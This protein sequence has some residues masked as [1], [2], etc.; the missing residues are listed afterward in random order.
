MCQSLLVPRDGTSL[1]YQFR[2]NHAQCISGEYIGC[3]QMMYSCADALRFIFVVEIE[4][5][6]L[7]KWLKARGPGV[8][9]SCSVHQELAGAWKEMTLCGVCMRSCWPVACVIRLFASHLLL[10]FDLTDRLS[11]HAA[12]RQHKNE[13]HVSSVRQY[14]DSS[15]II[16]WIKHSCVLHFIII[17]CV[18]LSLHPQLPP[19]C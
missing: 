18:D 11:P 5:M 1:L 10:A 13:W 12:I 15:W 3:M 14:T 19:R 8:C 16:R 7:W 2:I 4:M 17:T 6:E 9:T